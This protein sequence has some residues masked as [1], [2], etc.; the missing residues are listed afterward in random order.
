MESQISE[1]NPHGYDDSPEEIYSEVDGEYIG[2]LSQFEQ[3]LEASKD[4]VGVVNEY[5]DEEMGEELEEFRR[6]S[7]PRPENGE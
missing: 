4:L 3:H 7:D 2:I 6:L 5:V 1:D